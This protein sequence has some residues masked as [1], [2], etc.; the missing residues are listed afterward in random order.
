MIALALA[1]TL[2]A[3]L[4]APPLAAEAAPSPRISA[5]ELELLRRSL[6]PDGLAELLSHAAPLAQLPL[7]EVDAQLDLDNARID[8]H[9]RLLFTNRERAPISDLVLRLIPNA[10]SLKSGSA[11]RVDEVRVDGRPLSARSHGSVVEIPL[12][13]PLAP[14]ATLVLTL[15]FHGKLSRVKPGEDLLAPSAELLAQLAPG[16]GTMGGSSSRAAEAGA[17]RGYATFAVSQAGALLLDW[18]PQLAAR[19]GSAWDV[20]ETGPLGDSL[21]ADVSSALVSLSV[22]RGLRVE[23]AGV[24]LGQH[25]SGAG[26]VATFALAG[27]RGAL[28]VAVLRAPEEL[29]DEVHP[30]GDLR[31]PPIRLRAASLHG[32]AGARALLACARDALG[33]ISPRW[34]AYPWADLLLLE[35][36]LT[37]GAG[38]VEQSGLVVL[39]RGLGGG[40]A[41][42]LSG[43]TS[44]S[45]PLPDGPGLFSFTCHHEVAHQWFPSVVGSDPRRAPWLDEA[46]AQ[47][48]AV[49]VAQSVAGGGDA[50]KFAAQTASRRFVTL[51]YQAMR[52]LGHADGRV[53]RAADEFHSPVAYS[54]LIYGKAPLYL[55]A[56]RALIGDERF[57]EALRTLRGQRAFREGS[58]ADLLGAFAKADPARTEQLEALAARWLREKHGDEDIAPLDASDLLDSLGGGAPSVESLAQLVRLL[59]AAGKGANSGTAPVLDDRSL[60]RALRELEKSMPEL[61][62]LL[63][64]GNGGSGLP[65]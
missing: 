23:G 46:L 26:E 14:N 65:P 12:G 1:A 53:D 15:V 28:G 27:L 31:L 59:G 25:E 36:P 8:G 54:G 17:R 48:A 2:H 19:V 33:E 55:A 52:R 22:A 43:A 40:V 11:M 3:V 60:R 42:P 58:A 32:P 39:S 7:S 56:V 50:G 38:G 13:L 51:N 18:Y 4:A 34:G 49:R 5:D 63:Q 20:R 61:R 35:A 30:E 57:D 29:S 44:A 9:L 62:E 45:D 41:S 64:Q 21:H 47:D 6:R 16:L 37:G 24:A 10:P